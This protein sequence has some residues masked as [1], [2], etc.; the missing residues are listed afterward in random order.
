MVA[1]QNDIKYF[2]IKYKILNNKFNYAAL[3]T[4]QGFRSI[5]TAERLSAFQE[6]QILIL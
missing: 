6:Q 2:K 4:L 5:E 1:S 3:S